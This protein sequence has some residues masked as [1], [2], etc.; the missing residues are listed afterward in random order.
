MEKTQIT[1][2]RQDAIKRLEEYLLVI[3]KDVPHLSP[4]ERQHCMNLIELLKKCD[5]IKFVHFFFVTDDVDS[6]T[7][8][9]TSDDSADSVKLNFPFGKLFWNEFE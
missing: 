8:Y 3:S 5:Q 4:E 9:Y 2:D 1:L 7:L 6:I